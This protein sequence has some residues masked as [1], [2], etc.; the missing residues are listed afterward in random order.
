MGQL[1]Q[2][3]ADILKPTIWSIEIYHLKYLKITKC[4]FPWTVNVITF[5][6]FKKTRDLCV[7]MTFCKLV[8]SFSIFKRLSIS[9]LEA[10]SSEWQIYYDM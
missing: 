7:S 6:R 5:F 2:I 4:S 8:N 9:T 3:M 10:R 1:D